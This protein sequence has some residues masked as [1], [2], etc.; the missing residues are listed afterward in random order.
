[1]IVAR[2]THGIAIHVT[3]ANARD[4]ST[5]TICAMT[6]AF[7]ADRTVDPVTPMDV[8]NVLKVIICLMVRVLNV[9]LNMMVAVHVILVHVRYVILDIIW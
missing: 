8:M 9:V 6:R 3:G 2:F 1:M 5:V 4:A 7:G